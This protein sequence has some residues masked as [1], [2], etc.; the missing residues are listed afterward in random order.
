MIHLW[1]IFLV[2]VNECVREKHFHYVL[3]AMMANI[4]VNLTVATLEY[5]L[6]RD[7]GLQPL[8]GGAVTST[9]AVPIFRRVPAGRFAS[10]KSRST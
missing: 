9:T 7:L 2:I 4:A 1:L 8:C 6:R 5:L 3:V 10:L